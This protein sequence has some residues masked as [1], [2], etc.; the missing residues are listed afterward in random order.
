MTRLYAKRLMGL[1]IMAV[2][3]QAQSAATCAGAPEGEVVT[4]TSGG[5]VVSFGDIAGSYML[6]QV[7]GRDLPVRFNKDDDCREEMVRGS[8]TIR[9]DGSFTR[10]LT[11]RETCEGESPEEETETENGRVL[12]TGNT[13][14][15][16]N[17]ED[18]SAQVSGNL[19]LWT[20]NDYAKPLRLTFRR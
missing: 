16:D 15:F 6:V 8:L 7:N 9:N 10:S 19:I 13:L 18:D 14:T 2:A 5:A 3:L 12:R 17:D 20:T 4:T 1:A 11:E